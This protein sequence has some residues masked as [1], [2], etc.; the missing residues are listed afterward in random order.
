MKN[1]DPWIPEV[2][3]IVY[4][5]RNQSERTA[6]VRAVIKHEALVEYR[7]PNGVCFL[8]VIDLETMSKPK[9][10]RLKSGK[11]IDTNTT[12]DK[13]RTVPY[14][15]LPLKW[16]NAIR[17]RMG[18]MDVMLWGFDWSDKPSRRKIWDNTTYKFIGYKPDRERYRSTP[19]E[20]LIDWDA[21]FEDKI[22]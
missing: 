3:D 16:Q 9:P 20:D 13:Y 6:I 4:L 8:N 5:Y 11:L 14:L 17:G 18:I 2:G 19:I 21:S 10:H 7:M 22:E 1:P 15:K 12:Y